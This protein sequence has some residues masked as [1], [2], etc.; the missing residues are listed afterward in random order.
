MKVTAETPTSIAVHII[1]HAFAVVSVQTRFNINLANT[2]TILSQTAVNIH[3]RMLG[4]L[5]NR[6][7][8]YNDTGGASHWNELIRPITWQHWALVSL[9]RTP[10]EG[11]TAVCNKGMVIFG[12][13]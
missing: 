11:S 4:F 12:K 1:N 9:Q 6:C 13:W 2:I 5:L 7:N 8:I 10:V 3:M